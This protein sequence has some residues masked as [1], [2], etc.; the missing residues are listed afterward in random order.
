MVESARTVGFLTYP[1]DWF[2]QFISNLEMKAYIFTFSF[3]F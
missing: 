2:C 3:T 1:I